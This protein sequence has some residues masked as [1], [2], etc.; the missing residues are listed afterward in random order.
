M[1]TGNFIKQ[2]NHITEVCNQMMC[3]LWE[4]FDPQKVPFFPIRFA[5]DSDS[6]VASVNGCFD[7]G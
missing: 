3:D 1:V 5:L 4:T 6:C 2:K 7:I